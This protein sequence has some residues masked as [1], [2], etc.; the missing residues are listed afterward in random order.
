MS[1]HRT[2]IVDLAE[3]RTHL[4]HEPADGPRFASGIED[5]RDW[6]NCWAQIR[7]I[8]SWGELIG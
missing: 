3:R 4:L 8:P 2:P 6:P 7:A 1:G 5:E